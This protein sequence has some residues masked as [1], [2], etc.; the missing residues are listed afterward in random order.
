ER[1]GVCWRGVGAPGGRD[2]AGVRGH[3]QPPGGSLRLLCRGN[4]FG[5]G[6]FGMGWIRQ[7]PRNVLEYIAGINNGGYTWYAPSL[8][9]RVTISRDN[10]SVTLTM[11][12]LRNEDSGLYFCAR[13]AVA[14][15][16]R[17][18]RRPPPPLS[19]VPALPS[20]GPLPAR[21]FRPLPAPSLPAVPPRPL[22]SPLPSLQGRVTI[23]RDNG[24]S[25]VT[26]TMTDLRDEDSGLY[27]CAKAAGA[28]WGAGAAAGY[29]DSATPTP[30]S[31]PVPNP[32]TLPHT[33]TL[34]PLSQT[35][36]IPPNGEQRPQTQPVLPQSQRVLPQSQPVLPQSQPVLPKSQPVLPQSQPV[37]PQSQPVLPQTQPV[38]PKPS[39]FCPKTPPI[40]G[41]AVG[42]GQD[43]HP[44]SPWLPKCPKIPK[45][46][47]KS[48]PLTPFLPF[49]PNL[50]PPRPNPQFPPIFAHFHPNLP[51]SP[52]RLEEGRAGP[53][54]KVGGQ[55]LSL[56][57]GQARV[58]G[59]GWPW[60]HR[61]TQGTEPSPWGSFGVNR[62][63]PCSR[64]G[65]GS[66]P[67]TPTTTADPISFFVD[68]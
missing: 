10:S 35:C 28:G 27:L 57:R 20:S 7:T 60:G 12:D 17:I 13:A 46:F 61:G 66:H 18:D 54:V 29:G 45:S 9:G 1:G 5:F 43:P 14:V 48:Q 67:P 42:Y 64:P 16:G 50:R 24:Q 33:P 23:S 32:Q 49:P 65:P 55:G 36:P 2:P 38:L 15:P 25:S 53:G 19:P 21:G 47:P 11:T 41:A 58:W 8:Q 26:L 40:Y 44:D 59:Q 39:R 63:Q 34:G 30:V 4:G 68:P 3:L 52:A 22:L 62:C 31:P 56:G 37:L 51:G 6:R